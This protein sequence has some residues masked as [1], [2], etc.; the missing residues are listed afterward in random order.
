M[1]FFHVYNEDCF[2]GLEKNGLLNAD[3]G[4]KLQHCFAV[5]KDRLFNT[6]AAVGTPL[7]RLITENHIPFYV[8][9]IAG[10]ITYYPYAFD[11]RLISEYRQ[12]LGDDFLG[13]QLHE[14][15]SNRR[16]AEWPRMMR[17]TGKRGYFDPKELREKLVSEYC[18]KCGAL[19]NLSNESKTEWNWIRSPWPW[20]A[21]ANK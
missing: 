10:G 6:Y 21:D 4:F 14:S 1:K 17:V 19:T 3:S 5:P 2:K 12:A 7:H 20:E 15:A 18:S 11:K 16:W 8:D 9:R 13:F